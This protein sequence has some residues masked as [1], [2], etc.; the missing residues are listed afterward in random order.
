MTYRNRL[1]WY[2]L[3]GPASA[4]AVESGLSEATWFRCSIP[5]ARMQQLMK[6]SDE[7]A[8]RGTLLWLGL[9]VAAAAGAVYLWPSWWS[10]PLWLIYGVLY[11]SASETRRHETS[12]GTAFRTRRL[13]H[14]VLHVASFCRMR[15]PI[16]ERWRHTRHH[17]D[18][19]IVGRD[20]EIDV[21]RP[22]RLFKL[23]INLF[24]LIDVPVQFS[25]IVEHA[26]GH[27]AADERQVV[28]SSEG[29]KV[30]RTARV[31]LVIY[32]ATIT[33]AVVLRSWIPVLLI[34]GPQF[35]GC[36]LERIY[37]F[38]QHA[39]LGENVLDHR[40]NTRTILM[41]PINRFI[42]WDMN[43]HIEHHMFPMVPHHK[44][45][46]LHEELKVDMPPP[47]PSLFAA[48]REIIPAVIRQ[49]KDPTYF[50]KREL[51]PGAAPYN[52]P[53]NGLFVESLVV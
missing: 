1:R 42:Y 46:E 10:A 30:F 2:D 17:T 45:A 47:Y 27:L 37:S 51:P 11:S 7:P 9:A 5:R 15:D 14:V 25:L 24:G 49:L 52:P 3:D 34:G 38:T 44:L 4:F 53:V 41:G 43:Y 39:G 13:Q 50:I 22:A 20:L 26:F 31:W 16:V 18:T 19:L 8:I 28:P 32:A 12:H 29:P 21:M 48:Y 35:Y 33:S 36:F 6:R 40:L 23:F